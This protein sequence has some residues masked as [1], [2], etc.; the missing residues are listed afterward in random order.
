MVLPGALRRPSVPCTSTRSFGYQPFAVLR[1]R[2][3]MSGTD[4]RICYEMSGTDVDHDS[5]VIG[6]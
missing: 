3:E 2:Y 4:G 5:D 1:I 6:R